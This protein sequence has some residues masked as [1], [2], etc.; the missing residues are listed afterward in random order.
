[1]Q[2][3]Q[4]YFGHITPPTVLPSHPA[5]DQTKPR[6]APPAQA[7]SCPRAD[8]YPHRFDRI[9]RGDGQRDDARAYQQNADRLVDGRHRG[10]R[11]RLRYVALRDEK[12][13]RVLSVTCHCLAVRINK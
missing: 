4:K 10:G 12:A 5:N 8:L 2:G 9:Q 11:I 3:W 13:G 1:M 7:A 6:L